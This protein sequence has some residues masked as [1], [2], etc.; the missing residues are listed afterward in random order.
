M[1]V[2]GVELAQLKQWITQDDN[3]ALSAWVV[4]REQQ[5]N[6]GLFEQIGHLTRGLYDSINTL[7]SD[8]GENHSEQARDRLRFVIDRSQ[9]SANRVLDAVDEAQ[10]VAQRLLDSAQALSLKWNKLGARELSGAEFRE[11]YAEMKTFLKSTEK[12]C[13]DLNSGLQS[14]V[15]AQDFQDLTGQVL[16][17]VIE[18]LTRVE[19]SLVGLMADAAEPSE[20]TKPQAKANIEAGLGPQ[21]KVADDSVGSQADVDDLL[22]SLGF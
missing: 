3:D 17:R 10:P 8:S 22:S 13:N 19:H 18:M 4:E 9:D 21:A 20:A 12:D 16:E 7:Q 6:Q 5:A 11:L 1:S 15:L 14:I 2:S